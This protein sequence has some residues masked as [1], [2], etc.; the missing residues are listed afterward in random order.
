MGVC[1]REVEQSLVNVSIGI[2]EVTVCPLEWHI[3]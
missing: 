2:T 1:S 3:P